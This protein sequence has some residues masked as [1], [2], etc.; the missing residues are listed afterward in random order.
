MAVGDI[1]QFGALYVD[2]VEFGT[3]GYSSTGYGSTVVEYRDATTD[4]RKRI[5]IEIS[6]NGKKAYLDSNYALQNA[7]N[8]CMY[9][10]N[11]RKCTIEGQQYKMILLSETEWKSL[12]KNVLNQIYW[13]METLTSSF[14]NNN[15]NKGIWL[16]YSLNSSL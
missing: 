3:T 8:L 16:R 12:P 15:N 7:S 11:N 13:E 6:I 4:D 10:N 9:Y 5:F 2:G 1:K 14:D